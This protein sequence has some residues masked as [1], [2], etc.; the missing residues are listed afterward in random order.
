MVRGHSNRCPSLQ[1]GNTFSCVPD[2]LGVVPRPF[3]L[4]VICPGHLRWRFCK[5]ALPSIGLVGLSCPFYPL[6][7][8]IGIINTYTCLEQGLAP[9][10]S[11]W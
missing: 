5:K 8:D 4:C 7:R 10:P 9:R 6:P 3:V 1:E 2:G 11:K